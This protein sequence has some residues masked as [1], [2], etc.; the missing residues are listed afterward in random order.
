MSNNDFD[1]NYISSD[2]E[3]EDESNNSDEVFLDVSDGF[4][5]EISEEE[6][7]FAIDS[8]DDDESVI[9]EDQN[10]KLDS[11]A[12]TEKFKCPVCLTSFEN[13]TT[14]AITCG[15]VICESCVDTLADY[16]SNKCPVCKRQYE[17]SSA[18]KIYL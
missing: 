6:P 7:V 12:L 5:V 13:L 4:E 17:R 3:T 1:L 15:H 18:K 2:D 10:S 16:G 14:V 9:K 8:D 11:E